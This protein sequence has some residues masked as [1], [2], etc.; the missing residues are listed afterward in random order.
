[1]TA[2]IKS[3]F[4]LSLNKSSIYTSYQISSNTAGSFPRSSLSISAI[5]VYPIPSLLAL[6]VLQPWLKC[7]WVWTPA[8]ASIV[9]FS[10]L[11]KSTVSYKDCFLC[12]YSISREHCP[13]LVSGHPISFLLNFNLL[14][15]LSLVPLQSFFQLQLFPN[16]QKFSTLCRLLYN[17]SPRPNLLENCSAIPL[18][19][20]LSLTATPAHFSTNP[21]FPNHVAIWADRTGQPTYY[22]IRS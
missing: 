10:P 7:S 4:P 2:V 14:Q 16:S 1:M 17:F 20:L 22:P 11:F 19:V 21:C 13:S 8:P 9:H 15:A 18:S 3:Q 12:V 6:T 5:W